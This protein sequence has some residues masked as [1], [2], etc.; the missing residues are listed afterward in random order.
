MITGSGKTKT[1]V[2]TNAVAVAVTAQTLCGTITIREDAGV[3]NWPT[4]SYLIYKPDTNST[5]ITMAVGESYTFARA[6]LNN[7]ALYQPGEIAGYVKPASTTT[8]SQDER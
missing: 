1:F 4:T 2:A 5:P 6:E 3:V 8:F 7:P